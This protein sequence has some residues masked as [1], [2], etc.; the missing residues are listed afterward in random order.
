MGTCYDPTQ[1]SPYFSTFF[2][3]TILAIILLSHLSHPLACGTW[4]TLVFHSGK[5]FPLTGL[6][7]FYGVLVLTHTFV[8]LS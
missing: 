1:N 2:F 6:L 4:D 3:P 8:G 5:V 7:L